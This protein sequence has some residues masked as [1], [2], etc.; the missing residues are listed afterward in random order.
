MITRAL[1]AGLLVLHSG[2]AYPTVALRVESW[3]RSTHR[4]SP[5]LVAHVAADEGLSQISRDYPGRVRL[6]LGPVAGYPADCIIGRQHA[7]GSGDE[8]MS[9]ERHDFVGSFDAG[10][11]WFRL[12]ALHQHNEQVV[13]SRRVA[14]R[15]VLQFAYS[16]DVLATLE[17]LDPLQIGLR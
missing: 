6:W 15:L 17:G 14:L 12:D 9:M 4:G 8:G 10:S 13:L 11:F 16:Y 5:Y 2:C 1:A 3:S 7:A